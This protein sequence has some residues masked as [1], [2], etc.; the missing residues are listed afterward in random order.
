MSGAH[1]RSETRTVYLICAGVTLVALAARVLYLLEASRQGLFAG[2]FLDSQFY[3]RVAQSIR[4]GD[5]VGEHPYLLSPLY[6]YFLALFPSI[7][8]PTSTNPALAVRAVQALVGALTCGMT[9][10]IGLRVAGTA[11]G[12]AAGLVAASYGPLIHADASVQVASLDT[13]F[14][15]LALVLAVAGPA[16]TVA[17]ERLRWLGVGLTLGLAATLRPTGLVI[18]LAICGLLLV[19]GRTDRAARVAAA[20]LLAG[21]VLIVA[22]F[23]I[24]NLVVANEAVLLSANGGINLWVGNHRGAT[25]VFVPPPDYDFERDPVGRAYAERETGRPLTYRAAS[26]W[27]GERALADIG[28]APGR[29]VVLM[30]RKA[31][32]FVSPVEIP[33]L[34][35]N[36]AWYRDRAWPLRLPVDARW[37]LMLAF[38]APV[39]QLARGGRRALADLRWP[40]LV[41]VVYAA[42][43]CVF[44]VTGRYRIPLMPLT[45]VLAAVTCVGTWD[46]FVRQPG[47]RAR[48]ATLAALWLVV[49]IGGT[50]R[51]YRG[52]G[53]L[54]VR[55]HVGGEERHAG[56]SLYAQGRYDEAIAVY[57]RALSGR[58]DPRTRSALARALRSAGRR[59]EAEAEYRRVLRDDPRAAV[60]AYNLANLLWQDRRLTGEAERLFRQ[61]IAVR[62]RFAE[63]HFNLGAVLL[64][65]AR[66]DEALEPIATALR[67]AEPTAAWRGNAEHALDAARRAIAE[68]R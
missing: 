34:G 29:W 37:L 63:A 66:Y 3:A 15:T 20:A 53:P 23:A 52:G 41:L 67:L 32:L 51:L 11:V 44:F 57:R 56:M 54:F 31:L 45:I 61:A 5:G 22:P 46:L 33:Q 35:S 30:V 4:A 18:A 58:D 21:V 2:L 17:G 64:E 48:I 38:A 19:D 9:A 7:D 60:A 13:F 8:G 62:P 27:W 6:P 14:L 40:L 55:G 47:R 28:A 42:V 10:W 1:Q 50:H 16:A 39:V 36:F 43:T 12:I 24:R 26:R 49:A 25:G 59:D 65:Q 68:G